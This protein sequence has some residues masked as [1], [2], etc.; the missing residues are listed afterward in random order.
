[1][2]IG[3]SSTSMKPKILSEH[4][5]IIRLYIYCTNLD[6]VTVCLAHLICYFWFTEHATCRSFCC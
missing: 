3:F 2:Y 1:M 6:A 5:D 4:L